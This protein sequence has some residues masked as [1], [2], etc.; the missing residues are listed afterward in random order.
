LKKWASKLGGAD[1]NEAM[2][3]KIDSD[4]TG[5]LSISELDA[6]LA[7]ELPAGA[8]VET[9]TDTILDAYD[10]NKDELLTFDEFVTFI[11]A[12]PKDKDGL[13]NF[14]SLNREPTPEEYFTRADTNNDGRV[15]FDEAQVFLRSKDSTINKAGLN[16]VTSQLF[17][18]FD[19]DRNRTLNKDEF[20]TS[21]QD[22]N[23]KGG[24]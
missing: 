23:D 4:Q 2:F 11:E 15:S 9:I 20:L 19:D 17:T 13:P 12:L 16:Y 18:E 24:F 22:A 8:D 5:R 1:E 6:F 3:D 21:L 10:K 14:V 7:F